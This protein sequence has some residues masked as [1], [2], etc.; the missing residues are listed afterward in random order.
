MTKVLIGLGNPGKEYEKTRHNIGW[1]VLDTLA[2]D[3]DA[4]EF[5]ENKKLRALIAEGR[6]GSKKI[7][8]VKPLTFMNLSGECT[9]LI[10]NFYKVE[11]SDIT[12]LYDDIDLP[13]GTLRYRKE[14]SGGT[15]NGMKSIVAHLGENVPRLRL[16][17]DARSDLMKER[18]DLS[19][20]VLGSFTKTETP[21]VKKMLGDAVAFLL[22]E[23]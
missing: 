12:V 11:N 19:D 3:C 20:Y 16:G 8:F 10:K 1:I 7:I 14:G 5:K 9:A 21:L 4:E 6:H 23:K 2:R 18:M 15:H 13:L 17:I 22:H